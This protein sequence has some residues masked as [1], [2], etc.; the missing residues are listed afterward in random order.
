LYPGR[1]EQPAGGFDLRPVPYLWW[2]MRRVEAELVH[3][4]EGLDAVRGATLVEDE[5]LPHADDGARGRAA[6]L[7]VLP[8]GLPVPGLGGAVRARPRRVLTVP[9]AEEVPLARRQLR[10]VC[11][12]L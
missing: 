10:C 11:E 6:H 5:R 1:V 9:E 2:P 12:K 7:P 8:R 4:P 3:D